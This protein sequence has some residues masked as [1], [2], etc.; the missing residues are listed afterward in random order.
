MIYNVAQFRR[1]TLRNVQKSAIQNRKRFT[2]FEQLMMES[3]DSPEITTNFPIHEL[4]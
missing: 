3:P 1:M 2:I 4:S